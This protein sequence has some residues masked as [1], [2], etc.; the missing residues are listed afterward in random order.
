MVEKAKQLSESANLNDAQRK[1]SSLRRD[2]KRFEDYE[3]NFEEQLRDKFEEYANI[4]KE[5]RDELSKNAVE[6]KEEIIAKAKETAN[7]ASFKE[8]SKQMDE[9][10]AEWKQAFSAGKDKDE[11]LWAQFKE[12]RDDF[13]K[14]KKEYYRNLSAKFAASKAEKEEIIAKMEELAKSTDWKKTTVAIDE[15]LEKW[16]AAGSAGRGKD[17]DLWKRFS[18]AR[19]EFNSAKNAYYSKLR[20]EFAGRVEKKEALIAEAKKCVAQVDFSK[21]MV[22]KV[23]DLRTQWKEIGTCGREKEDELWAEFNGAINQF[24]KNM[25]DYR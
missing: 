12:V 19:K 8:A 17:D 24:F 16:K 18:A 14:K 9:L 23:K 25:R 1:L 5:K 4:V 10:M 2:W 13:F 22:E 11:E 6:A 21:E 7:L 20:E 15:L 3:S